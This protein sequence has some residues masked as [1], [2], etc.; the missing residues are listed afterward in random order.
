[1]LE[2][3]LL[4]PFGI[5]RAVNDLVDI[6]ETGHSKAPRQESSATADRLEDYQG[7]LWHKGETVLG[8]HFLFFAHRVSQNLDFAQAL[9]RCQDPAEICA[10]TERY[11]ASMLQDYTTHSVKQFE[12]IQDQL[13][14][15]L[16]AAE[17][18]QEVTTD[19]LDEIKTRS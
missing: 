17:R 10:Q 18:L 2:S 8:A 9:S 13:G 11:M 16:A 19:S 4:D 5:K 12:A 6:A 15:G 14:T 3:T 1:M 7:L